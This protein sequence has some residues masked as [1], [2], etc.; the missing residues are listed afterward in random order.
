MKT[1]SKKQ[2]RFVVPFRST[3]RNVI[4]IASPLIPDTD[5]IPVGGN[6]A[7]G[8]QRMERKVA[9]GRSSEGRERR[10]GVPKKQRSIIDTGIMARAERSPLFRV[11]FVTDA[12]DI[13]GSLASGN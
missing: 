8:A 11:H 1:A 12:S 13:R 6:Y 9:R 4:S 5:R 7:G 10:S 2:L 3:S